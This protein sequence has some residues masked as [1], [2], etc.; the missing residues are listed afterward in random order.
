MA[1]PIIPADPVA[2]ARLYLQRGWRIVPIPPHQKAPRLS[3]W[4]NLRLTE[5]ELELYLPTDSPNLGVLLGSPSGGL[6]DVDLDAP[7][8]RAVAPELLPPTGMVH[9]RASAPRSHFWYHCPTLT[10]SRIQYS[11]PEAA[12]E[13]GK[14]V[15]LLEIRSTG[16]QTVVPPSVH[17]SGEQLVW[18]TDT[19]EPA[20]VDAD[21][22]KRACCRVAAAAVL[23][24]RWREG[25]RN[26][27]TLALAGYLARAGWG[28]DDT[29]RFMGA[30]CA[31]A[32]D[33]EWRNR[34]E[35]VR[36]TFRKVARGEPC[37]GLPTLTELLGERVAERLSEWLGGRFEFSNEQRK[38]A[39][40]IA[41][42]PLLSLP[43]NPTLN[44]P[45]WWT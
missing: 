1:V 30:V 37:T 24:A 45:Q 43:P 22:L 21:A 31:A 7:L 20:T 19:L 13:G 26:D 29:L 3:G 36:A 35:A 16:H 4:Q 23:A 12:T 18:H 39:L 33:R 38:R 10:E 32:G 42:E 17:P 41:A 34:L 27:L 9:G 40:L 15:L 6:C 25:Y 5:D 28:E 14:P 11:D 8:A 2:A 44:P